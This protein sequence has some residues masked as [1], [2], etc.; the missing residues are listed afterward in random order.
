MG[1]EPMRGMFWRAF[2]V[3]LKML[4]AGDL[5][6]LL[7]PDSAPGPAGRRNKRTPMAPMNE[8]DLS[9][10]T[11]RWVSRAC[12]VL[13]CV[14]VG[15]GIASAAAGTPAENA[16]RGLIQRVL[17]A[18]ASEIEVMQIPGAEGGSDVFEVESRAGRLL[19]KGNTGGA[20][21]AGLGWYLTNVAHAQMSWDGDNL[22][23]PDKLPDVPQTVRIVSP[24]KYRAY[25]NYCT[26]NYTMS[27][28]DKARWERE[29]DWMALHGVTMPLATTGQEAVW[30]ATLREL[31]MSDAEIR[32]F[33]VGPAYSGW[34]WLTNIEAW[35]GP[36]PQS[37]IDS[38]LELGRFVLNREREL[39]M[40]P[41]LQGFSGCVP[42]SFRERF[43]SAAI[44]TKVIWCEVPPGTAQLDPEDPLFA[45]VGRLF[46]QKQQ[47]L[48]GPGHLYAAD[49]FHEGEPPK[50]GQAYLNSVGA[51]IYALTHEFD[52]EAT[53]V[54]Q[55]WT[56]RE[57]IVQGIPSD[58]LLVLD[59]TGEKWKETQ[60][61]WGRPWIAG[62]LHNFGGRTFLGGNLPS[63]ANNAAGLL[64]NPAAG[65]LVGIGAFPEAI[66]QNPVVYDLAFDVG[67]RR[68]AP[69]LRPWIDAFVTARYGR[70]LPGAL[71][72][73]SR[74]QSSV[75]S[76]AE[77]APSMDSPFCAQ[78][79]LKL[80]KASPWGSFDRNYPPGEVWEAWA[81]LMSAGKELGAV[82]TFQYDLVDVARQALA[83]LSVPLYA[84]V[85][86]AFRSG[87][88][89]RFAAEKARFLELAVDMDKLLATRREFLL[90]RWVADA[91]AWGVS[92]SEKDQFEQNARLLLTLWG[93]PSHGAFLHDYACRQWAGLLAGFYVKRWELFFDYLGKQPAGY[94]EDGL[95]RVMDRPGDESSDFYRTLTAWEYAWCKGHE[96]SPA[97]PKGDPVAVASVLLG[98]WR[99]VMLSAYPG[100]AWKKPPDTPRP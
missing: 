90:G 55:G 82:D 38:H 89:V 33:L 95:Y 30:Q 67:W 49:P 65:R 68:T 6:E 37:W 70:G 4:S 93:P 40:T 9:T 14:W 32:T 62:V 36:L 19:L 26:F 50:E 72:A 75:Y 77:S 85:V 20:I 29:I 39:G 51:R 41:I 73:W 11:S 10:S 92:Q 60:A 21:S 43:P 96:A 5:G 66:E 31:G 100:F 57:G 61:F 74:L 35:A 13:V 23:L 53:I 97:Q 16:A 17:P 94:S 46:L 48:L 27:W 98:K 99:P 47:D 84:D 18:H 8:M 25:L 71:S 78:P 64:G 12:G 86:K 63:I 34:Q 91:R 88:R 87:D 42:L 1:N 81:D 56:I 15:A 22:A 80:E 69:D 58:R 28:W 45:K 44:Q 3:A 79:A 76:Q 24:Y 7:H 83:D 59:L 2:L 54:M 52:P